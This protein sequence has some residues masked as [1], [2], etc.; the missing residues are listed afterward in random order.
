MLDLSH[1]GSK[2]D[3]SMTTNGTSQIRLVSFNEELELSDVAGSISYEQPNDSS[4][5]TG[6]AH[7]L[8][9]AKSIPARVGIST[10]N[11]KTLLEKKMT[12]QV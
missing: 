5:P 8:A 2:C 3:D 10:V 12:V 4:V 7:N 1:L 11:L 6:A 9:S